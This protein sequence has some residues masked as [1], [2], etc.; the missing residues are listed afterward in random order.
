[1]AAPV[2]AIQL[3]DI[4]VGGAPHRCVGA[5]AVGAVLGAATYKER[6]IVQGADT[7]RVRMKLSAVAG[8]ATCKVT[9][10][11]AD[12]DSGDKASG[13]ASATDIVTTATL[14][15]AAVSLDYVV[16]G[17]RVVDVSIVSGTSGT[18]EYVDLFLKP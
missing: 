15:T 13:T 8:T 17:D 14:T 10:V 16:V 3:S 9:P 12:G 2:P 6:V 5:L 1:M 4:Q 11:L 7:L 18:I